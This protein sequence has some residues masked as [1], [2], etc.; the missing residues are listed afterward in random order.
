MVVVRLVFHDDGHV[1]ER[2]EEPLGN[3]SERLFHGRF[4]LAVGHAVHGGLFR[5]R[6]RGPSARPVR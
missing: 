1:L 4:E 2:V 3:A 5:G 6:V